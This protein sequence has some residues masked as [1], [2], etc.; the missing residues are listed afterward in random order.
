MQDIIRFLSDERNTIAEV[1]EMINVLDEF[2]L[3]EKDRERIERLCRTKIFA[4][5]TYNEMKRECK[6]PLYVKIKKK[7]NKND[8]L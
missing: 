1:Y 7:E 6:T 8:N 4:M 5:N 3:N 2:G